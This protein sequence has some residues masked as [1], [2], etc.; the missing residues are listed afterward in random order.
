MS[1]W[2]HFQNDDLLTCSPVVFL[3]NSAKL[4]RWE[5]D[6]THTIRDIMETGAHRML[7]FTDYIYSVDVCR[8]LKKKYSSWSVNTMRF[9]NVRSV[10]RGAVR[11][12]LNDG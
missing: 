1:L 2:L 11:D 6:H 3:A 9:F 10:R 4:V 5:Y 8:T 12:G 7:T